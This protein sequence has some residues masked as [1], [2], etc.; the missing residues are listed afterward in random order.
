MT[1]TEKRGIIRI[2]FVGKV[3]NTKDTSKGVFFFISTPDK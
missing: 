2:E 1:S 3:L